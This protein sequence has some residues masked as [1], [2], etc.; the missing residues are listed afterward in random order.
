MTAGMTTMPLSMMRWSF[1][2]QLQA[3]ARQVVD[4]WERQK[5]LDTSTM[6]PASVYAR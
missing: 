6:R 5:P 4:D 2:D 1:Q 3:T